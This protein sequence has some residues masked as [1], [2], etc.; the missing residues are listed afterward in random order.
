MLDYVIRYFHRNGPP[1]A[2]LCPFFTCAACG[3][4]AYAV[5]SEEHPLPSYVLWWEAAADGSEWKGGPFTQQLAVVHRMRCMDA[6]EAEATSLGLGHTF[7]A[8][9]EDF[10]KQASYNA[11]HPLGSDRKEDHEYPDQA[12]Y[13]APLPALWRRGRYSR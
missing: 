11:M 4:P 6:V 1:A 9:P 7:S 2:S 13:I 8:S 10:V 5:P 12:E 3:E